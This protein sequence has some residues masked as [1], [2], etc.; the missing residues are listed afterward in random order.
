VS[1][2]PHT[3]KFLFLKGKSMS[4]ELNEAVGNLKV[5]VEEVRGTLRGTPI[6]AVEGVTLLKN[7]KFIVDKAVAYEAEQEAK[8]EIKE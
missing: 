3:H 6:S 7:L 1:Q 5:F 8:K 2:L 4:P